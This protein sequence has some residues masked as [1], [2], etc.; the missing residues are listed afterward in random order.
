MA[1]P[2]PKTHYQ[3]RRMR[4]S[5]IVSASE[6]LCWEIEKLPASEQQTKV[7]ILASNLRQDLSRGSQRIHVTFTPE[8][9]AMAN[10]NIQILKT[11]ITELERQVSD[12]TAERDRWD[13]LVTAIDF[14][15]VRVSA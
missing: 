3:R 15:Q 7:S 8:E 10:T 11:R 9:T 5:E 6:E 4:M 12:L 1:T 2:S 13:K 14:I